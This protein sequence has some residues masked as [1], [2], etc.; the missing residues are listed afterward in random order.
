M[1]GDTDPVQANRNLREEPEARQYRF[2]LWCCSCRREFERT[3][4]LLDPEKTMR[5]LC[6]QGC[7]HCDEGGKLEIVAVYPTGNKDGE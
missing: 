6:M 2:L 5:A 1:H 7:A 4:V 3:S